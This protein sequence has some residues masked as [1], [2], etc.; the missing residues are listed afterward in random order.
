MARTSEH[1]N[2]HREPT[3]PHTLAISNALA[4]SNALAAHKRHSQPRRAPKR[5]FVSVEELTAPATLAPLRDEELGQVPVVGD[6]SE[7]ARRD[8]MKVVGV[9]F[10]AVGAT[11]CARLPERHVLPYVQKPEETVPGRASWYAT[12]CRTCSAGCGLLMKSRD[13]RPIKVEGNPE[14]PLSQGGVCAAGQAGVLDL[15]DG[16]RLRAPL[17]AGAPAKWDALDAEVAKGLAPYAANGKALAIVTPTVTGPAS[18]AA[19]AALQQRFPGARHVVHE[20]DDIGAIAAAH[21]LTHSRHLVPALHFDRAEY[22]LAFGADYLGTWLQPAAFTKQWAKTRA[23]SAGKKSMSH[24]IQVETRLSLTGSNADERVRVLPSELRPLVLALAAKIAADTGADLG[25]PANA[26]EKAALVAQWAK[27]LLANKGKS[28]VVADD[29]D[30]AVQGAVAFINQQL[31]NYGATLDLNSHLQSNQGD[32]AAEQAL[33]ADIGSGAVTGLILCGVNPAYDSATPG[34]WAAAIQKAAV[35]IAVANRHDETAK[36][37]KIVAATSHALESWGDL[38]TIAGTLTVQQPLV[39]PLFET[40]QTEDSLLVWAGTQLGGKQATFLPFMQATWQAQVAPRVEKSA[41]GPF[42]AFWDKAVHDGYVVVGRER[43]VLPGGPAEIAPP[44]DVSP[45]ALAGEVSAVG[46][47][48]AATP[49]AK[50][51]APPPPL[52]TLE[53]AKKAL[54]TVAAK[55]TGD[56]KLELVLFPTVGLRHGQQANNPFLHEMPDPISKATWGNYACLSPKTAA[57]LGVGSHDVVA[58]KAGG[59]VLELPVVLSPGLHDGAVAVPLGYGRTAVGKIGDGLGKNAR[60]LAPNGTAVKADVAKTGKTE[61]VAFSQTHHSYE[62]RDCVRETSLEEWQH[63]PT[64]GNEALEEALHD[65]TNHADKRVTRTLWNRHEYPGHKWG[66]A[67]DLNKCT[68]CGSCVVSCN[69]ENNVPVVGK[70]EVILRREMHWMRI[71]RYFSERDPA[72]ADGQD[73]T[74]TADDL[75]ALADNPEVVHM[76]MLCQQCD[77]AP[78]ETVCPVLATVHSSEG[79]NTQAY[80]RCIGTRYCAN[81]CPYKVRRFNW[82]NYPHGE[83]EG[84][85]DVDLVALALNPDVSRRSRGVMEKCSFCIQRIQDV[86]A[87]ASREG[88][89]DPNGNGQICKPNEVK[90]ACQQSCPAEAITFGDMNAASDVRQQYEDP[91]N[92]S[93]LV[94]VGTQPAVTYMT[95]VRNA[96]RPHAAAGHEHSEPKAEKAAHSEG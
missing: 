41:Q 80:N 37:C 77:N 10:A 8:F 6:G 55:V 78:C 34:A 51:E 74:P 50:L 54:A 64:A 27:D 91:R 29:A 71:D 47:A 96:A 30:V 76:P 24:T 86:K 84:K 33:L 60:L 45:V 72:P 94:E 92:Y 46:L 79:L 57:A 42:Q 85:Q 13:G 95:K 16:D 43:V 58:V 59:A 38:E 93:A 63:E 48:A 40:R 5:R 14:H 52:F 75:L 88:R 11:A 21:A 83:M 20:A 68:G 12:A 32:A 70:S 61:T 53:G 89:V 15:Y 90:T 49:E 9:T 25:L 22:V 73:W 23:V 7:L 28:L 26:G 44:Q 4:V 62:H 66:M 67:I 3:A 1:M 35:S 39:N 69:I 19:I 36:L 17:L 81:N 65:P 56:G 2:E 18:L 87:L 82:F 31:G